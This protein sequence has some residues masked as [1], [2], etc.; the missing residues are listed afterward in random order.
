MTNIES[1]C[2][3][4]KN[5]L[6]LSMRFRIILTTTL[7]SFSLMSFSQVKDTTIRGVVIGF[8]YSISIFPLEWREAPINAYGEPMLKSETS[9]TINV[10][11]TALSKY[12]SA[13][14]SQN[15]DAIY[16]L[17]QMKF[18]DVAYGGTNSNTN[19]YLVNNGK[20]LG[21]SDKY[22]EQTFH[23]EFSSIL[24][25]NFP[26]YL[27]TSEWKK[28]NE[29]GFEYNDPENGVG[30]IRNNLSSQDL[31][32]SLCRKGVLTQYASSSIE[33]DINSFAQNLFSPVEDFWKY[34]DVYPRIRQKM[35]MLVA[36]YSKISPELNEKFF[37]GIKE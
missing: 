23:H 1:K 18:F 19:V 32:T 30:A 17:S 10:M 29:R 9:R 37:R 8:K 2:S 5:F 3:D 36:F 12:P 24:F 28:F 25:R 21:Y 4:H 22:L 33:N 34:V 16:F 11:N 13:L 6:I 7:L 27:D 26:Q 31:D 20:S 15:L 14:L 35:K